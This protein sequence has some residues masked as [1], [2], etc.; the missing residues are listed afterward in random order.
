MRVKD[1]VFGSKSEKQGFRHLESTW[2]SDYRIF[3]NLP[4]PMVIEA[5]QRMESSNFFF[6]TSVDYVVCTREGRPLVAIDFDGRGQGFNREDGYVQFRETEDPRR[7]SKFDLKCK[8][9]KA[10]HLPYFVVA[11][12]ELEHIYKG[13]K[14]AV[15]DGL[16]GHVIASR[17]CYEQLSLFFGSHS[18]EIDKLPWWERQAYI[19]WIGTQQEV[20]SAFAYNP[21]VQKLGEVAQ[22]LMDD[23]SLSFPMWSS[24]GPLADRYKDGWAGYFCASTT[25]SVGDVSSTVWIRNFGASSWSVAEAIAE[26]TLY[27]K[28]YGLLSRNR[29]SDRVPDSL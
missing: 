20:A 10:A 19:D 3:P 21:I 6:K 27:C 14:L 1:S 28:L 13:I 25:T 17:D 12:E 8:W 7:K 29:G 22:K 18:D 9:A 16:I 5:E 23:F 2:R 11:S 24:Q 26:L 15:V 4:L